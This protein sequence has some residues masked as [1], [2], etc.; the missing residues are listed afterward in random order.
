MGIFR[1]AFLYITRK[2]MRSL[3]LFLI[4]FVTGLFLL[5]GNS[6]KRSAKEAAEDFQKTLKT[7]VRVEMTGGSSIECE[8][9][10]DENGKRC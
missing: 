9:T 7:G 10:F 4:F 2:K 8:E 5:T 3:L 1:R 6:I